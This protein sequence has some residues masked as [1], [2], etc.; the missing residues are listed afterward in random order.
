[1]SS[2]VEQ[3]SAKPAKIQRANNTKMDAGTSRQSTP[4]AKGCEAPSLLKKLMIT[5]ATLDI[6]TITKTASETN[7]LR[8]KKLLKPPIRYATSNQPAKIPNASISVE[9]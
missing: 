7:G 1:M 4:V 9:Q 6:R 2:R 3:A 5:N 8:K